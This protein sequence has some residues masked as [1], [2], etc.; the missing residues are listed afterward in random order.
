MRD[1]EAEAGK[2]TK[3]LVKL[4]DEPEGYHVWNL[5]QQAEATAKQALKGAA[6][7]ALISGQ[8]LPLALLPPIAPLSAMDED[9][10]PAVGAVVPASPEPP[11]RPHAESDDQM[12]G[13][14]PRVDPPGTEEEC[15][16]PPNSKRAP[17]G[18]RLDSL[19]MQKLGALREK[20]KHG[21]AC[22]GV[23]SSS[24]HAPPDVCPSPASQNR[25]E[26]KKLLRLAEL[27]SPNSKALLEELAQSKLDL[28]E[29]LA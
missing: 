19:P 16:P 8:P 15:A 26:A 10:T 21:A 2:A 18:R 29:S 3:L 7:A 14:S 27:Q 12:D 25:S 13:S 5:Q 28:A 11:P 22:S 6:K 1:A 17:H 24:D 4:G 23:G 20:R 9:P